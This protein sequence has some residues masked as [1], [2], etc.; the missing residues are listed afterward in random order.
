[1][2]GW[3]VDPL[4]CRFFG[5]VGVGGVVLGL[6]HLKYVVD[7]FHFSNVCLVKRF[8]GWLFCV[9][10]LGTNL[11]GVISLVSRTLIGSRDEL[12]KL[13]ESIPKNA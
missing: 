2:V 13:I 7:R 10:F 3:L 9:K 5:W 11:G 1:L 12:K 6:S 8:M 4:V